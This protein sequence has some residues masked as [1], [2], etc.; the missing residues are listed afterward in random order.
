MH[1]EV[2]KKI[3]EAWNYKDKAETLQKEGIKLPQSKKEPIE[4]KKVP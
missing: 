4:S 1:L 3:L 2:E